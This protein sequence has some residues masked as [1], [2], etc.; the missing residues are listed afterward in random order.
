MELYVVRHGQTLSNVEKIYNYVNEDLNQAGII[1]AH[2][3]KEK[4]KDITFDAVYSSPLLRARHTARILNDNEDIILYDE[5]LREREHGTLEGKPVTVTNRNDYW[6]YYKDVKDG[7]S[8]SV[9]ELFDRVK[10]FL[11]ELKT[12]DYQRALIITHNGVARAFHAYFEG[13]PED[14]NMLDLGINNTE[15]KVYQL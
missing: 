3:L 1:Q 8:E 2:A 7:N 14:G 9:K 4:I 13:I 15:V 5:R 12:K 11:D 10:S 6:N